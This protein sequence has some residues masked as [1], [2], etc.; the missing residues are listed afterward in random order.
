MKSNFE[1]DHTRIEDKPEIKNSLWQKFEQANLLFQYAC[2][3]WL[4][5]KTAHFSRMYWILILLGFIVFTG[6][7]SIYVIVKSFSGNTN[8]TVTP[9]IK[10]ANPISSKYSPAEFNKIISKAEFEKITR[11]RRYMD[12]LGRSPTG[13]KTHDS[14]VLYRPGLLDSLTIIE[15]YY[16][17]HLKN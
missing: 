12:S 13:K 7:C 10:P 14:I 5:K 3:N 15:N 4:E 2:A 9:I 17:S 11:F 16:Y 1:D 6:S 8:I